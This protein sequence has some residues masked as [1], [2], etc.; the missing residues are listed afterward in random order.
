M[1][2]EASKLASSGTTQASDLKRLHGSCSLLEKGK[3]EIYLGALLIP[4]GLIPTNK[5]RDFKTF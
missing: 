3:L 2:G 5:E 1:R 4:I